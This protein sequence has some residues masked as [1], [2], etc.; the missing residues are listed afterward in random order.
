MMFENDHYTETITN[1]VMRNPKFVEDNSLFNCH[2]VGVHSIALSP[3]DKSGGMIRLFVA[4]PK[5][6]LWT[7]LPEH[8]GDN[9][10]SVAFHPHHCGV[11]LMG[12]RGR[13][14]NWI[15][16]KSDFGI[17]THKH[18]YKSAIKDDGI[19]FKRMGDQ[20][21]RTRS[22][23]Y[24]CYGGFQDMAAKDIHTVAI[25]EG[26]VAAWLVMELD[27]DK[28]YKSVC[29]SNREKI[30][31]PRGLYEKPTAKAIRNLLRDFALF[32]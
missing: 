12:I 16:D 30:E 11:R 25:P 29:Y 3:K 26:K 7:N 9:M 21:M 32:E 31:V 19:S 20:C 6:N 1:F 8:F 27:E 4:T 23:G 18:R 2:A 5:H 24:L 10:M 17:M 14:M 13:F 15:V 22:Y 28:S